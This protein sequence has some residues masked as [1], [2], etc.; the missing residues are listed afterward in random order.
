MTNMQVATMLKAMGLQEGTQLL[1]ATTADINNT[2]LQAEEAVGIS[3]FKVVDTHINQLSIKS[4]TA[5]ET[6]ARIGPLSI[7]GQAQ[8]W[9]IA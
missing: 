5:E 9:T 3:E 1:L 6:K 8:I 7:Q 2:W 4:N